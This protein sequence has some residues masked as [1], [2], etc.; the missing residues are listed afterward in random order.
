MTSATINATKR[1]L[2]LF[3]RRTEYTFMF[4][5]IFDPITFS[6]HKD[7]TKPLS[8]HMNHWPIRRQLTP[9]HNNV[10][11]HGEKDTRSPKLLTYYQIWHKYPWVKT[12]KNTK[13]HSTCFKKKYIKKLPPK[14][15]QPLS[16]IIFLYIY[17]YMCFS[18]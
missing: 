14:P 9:Q 15:Y 12:Y 1:V 18:Q 17:M 6:L 16:C 13:K 3:H 10:I 7:L 2:C 4:N 8:S 11:L 5:H